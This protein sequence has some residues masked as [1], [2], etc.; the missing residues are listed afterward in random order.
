MD[1]LKKT[2]L[3][4]ALI[5]VAGCGQSKQGSVAPEPVTE[6]KSSAV[7]DQTVTESRPTTSIPLVSTT[8]EGTA[9]ST[10]QQT[11][12]AFQEGRLETVFDFLPP[13]YQADVNT[14][15]HDFA[16]K[17]DTEI[18]STSFNLLVKVA[19][20]LKSKKML[21]LSLD[22]VKRTP[23]IESIKHWDAIASGIHDI[24]SSEVADL[25]KLKQTD[26][27][28]LLE[29]ASNV[30]RRMPLPRFG[31]VN[32]VTVKSDSNTAT[33]SYRE[34][35]DA[36]PKQVEF[37]LIEGKWLPKSIADGWS[38]GVADA[39][40][41][42]EEL[43]HQISAVKPEAMRQIDAIGEMIEQLQSAKTSDEFNAAA[44]PLIFT[45]AF[46]AQMAQQSMREAATTPRKGSAVHCIINRE[47]NDSQLT[48]LKDAVMA[49]LNT[50]SPDVDYE[51]IP[52]NGKTRC[53]FIPVSDINAL[54]ALVAKHFD[55]AEVRLDLENRTIHVDLK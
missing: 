43:P 6:A 17:M 38:S 19:N 26:V 30:F 10:F 7:I 21:I 42:L 49:T 29:S 35:I 23:Q 51:L 48:A 33:L 47:L 14:L 54:T 36:N 34:T 27:R 5:C 28:G 18:W 50:T 9:E 3:L 37:V 2:R 20:L 25:S 4:F 31:D 53:R 16:G 12:I 46:G 40:A 39:K 52:N 41:M 24:A 15:V 55:A 44:A 32:V 13:S 1:R 45:I 11:L 22:G 8:R